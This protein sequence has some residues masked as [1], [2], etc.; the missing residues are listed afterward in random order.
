MKYKN[1]E[2]DIHKIFIDFVSR[3]LDAA[4]RI[5]NFKYHFDILTFDF[6]LL[7]KPI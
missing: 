5:I 4:I 7:A 2:E 6:W 1:I 3:E